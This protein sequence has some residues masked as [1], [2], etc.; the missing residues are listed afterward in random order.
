MRKAIA[1]MILAAAAG[2]ALLAAAPDVVEE[3]VA[4]VN[5]DI[6]TL[7]QYRQQFDVQIKQLKTQ[8]L[9]KD[10][11]DKAYL[12]VK[13]EL[14]NAMITDLLLLQE[15]REKNLNVNEEIK[16]N[17]AAIKKENNFAT[18]EDLRRA[19]EQQGMPYEQWRKQYEEALL[20]QLVLVQDVYRSIA[21]D[22]SEVVQY[23]KQHPKEFAVPAEFKVRAIYLVAEGRTPQALDDLKAQI[24]AKLKAGEAFAD[25]AAALSDPPMKDAKGELGTFKKG[26]LDPALEDPVEKMKANETSP[27]LSVKNGWYL[28]RLDEKKD[29]YQ[30]TFDEARNAV[31]DKLTGEKRQKKSEEYLNSLRERSYIKILKPNPLDY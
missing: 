23:Y 5:D 28:L 30:K 8:N 2:A 11:Y 13:S 1:F 3:I 18:D 29:G 16:N 14:L 17:I 10:D 27:W 4:I 9:A 21:L 20:K 24:S 15:A 7:S 6:I 25:V 22:E 31:E 26:E 12:Q 19:I